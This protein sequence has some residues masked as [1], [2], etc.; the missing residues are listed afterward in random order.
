M[1]DTMILVNFSKREYLRGI[2][3][4][5]PREWLRN[6]VD[7]AMTIWYMF[8]NTRDQITFLTEYG[9]EKMYRLVVEEF[10]DANHDVEGAMLKDK[11]LVL[12]QFGYVVGK[13]E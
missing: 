7:R 12:G 11:M 10:K 9:N 3:S 4:S 1:G 13:Y 8:N 2:R 6:D 5:K